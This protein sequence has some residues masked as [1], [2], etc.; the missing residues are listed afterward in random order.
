MAL[1]A[2]LVACICWCGFESSSS[3]QHAMRAACSSRS[4]RSGSVLQLRSVASASFTT[5][6]GTNPS[7]CP[8]R[9]AQSFKRFCL[10]ERMLLVRSSFAF[11]ANASATIF[12]S[13]CSAIGAQAG[14]VKHLLSNAPAISCASRASSG[15]S[16]TSWYGD[17]GSR[18]SCAHQ[19]SCSNSFCS[20]GVSESALVLSAYSAG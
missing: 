6:W 5:R 14:A 3:G 4:S 9:S 2:A 15:V 10:M 19:A 20:N 1:S 16:V 11:F 13:R 8:E 12:A 7:A 18:Q 17:F